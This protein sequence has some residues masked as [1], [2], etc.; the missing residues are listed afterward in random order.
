MP[1][2]RGWYHFR[3]KESERGTFIVAEPAGDVLRSVKGLL[4]FDLREGID[5]QEAN[6]IADFLNRNLTCLTLTTEGKTGA[7][8][9]A[10]GN[11]AP[12][13]DDHE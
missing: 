4:G 1:T 2:E 11:Y 9:Q 5:I 8:D 12:P 13:Q 3:T 6:A 10:I 7:P